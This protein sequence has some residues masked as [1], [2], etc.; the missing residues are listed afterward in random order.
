MWVKICGITSEKDAEIVGAFSPDAVGLMFYPPSPR[1]VTGEMARS[2][3]GVLPDRIRKVGVFVD[4]EWAEV[5]RL[6][7]K[8]PLD[9]IQWHGESLTDELKTKLS[10][11]GIPW[12]EV[13]K[14]TSG[15]VPSSLCLNPSAGAS[16]MLVEGASPKSP[17]G[18][19]HVWD[20]SLMREVPCPVPLILSGGLNDGNVYDAM[21]AV[22][23]FGVDVSSGVEISPGKKSYDRLSRFFSEVKRYG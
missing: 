11:L 20:Y 21:V 19:A 18:N 2:I 22:R 3:A 12:I 7:G 16:Y 8:V 1:H 15:M 10:H 5:E 6:A 23:P 13:K 17:G 4:M 9:M 14:I